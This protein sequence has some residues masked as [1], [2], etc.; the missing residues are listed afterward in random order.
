MP[1]VFCAS[2]VPCESESRLAETIWPSR[3]PRVDRARALAPDD[4]VGD[5]DREP[6][7][8]EGEHRRDERRHDDL[9]DEPVA[10]AR[11][12][13]P[14]ATNAEP[15]TPPISAC[16]E[17]RRQPEVPGGEVPGDRADEAG[18]HDRRR[19]QVGVDD[20]VGDRRRHLE[21]DERADEVQDRGDA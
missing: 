6:A 19:D 8:D 20:A 16:E 3:K 14:S 5:E 13:G 4:P 18:E 9:L 10:V 17:R 21:R 11:A 15:T 2:L 7:D 12:S 1:I